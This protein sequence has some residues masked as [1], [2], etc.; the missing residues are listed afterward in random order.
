MCF[1]SNCFV[2]VLPAALCNQHVSVKR[3][4]PIGTE[5]ARTWSPVRSG[6][7]VSLFLYLIW[8]DGL[9]VKYIFV[10]ILI[11][12]LNFEEPNISV[13]SAAQT[14]SQFVSHYHP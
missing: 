13:T 9:V 4:R 1:D 8:T 6:I 10:R 2:D 14:Q 11:N 12:L 7:R 3:S 5:Y